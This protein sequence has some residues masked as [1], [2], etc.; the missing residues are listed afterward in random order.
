MK[1]FKLNIC[2]EESVRKMR[3]LIDSNSLGLF[4]VV[5]NAGIGDNRAFDDW[6]T[7]QMYQRFFDVNTLGHIRVTHVN[8]KSDRELKD[9]YF[10]RL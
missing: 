8:L 9:L 4:A 6:Q 3:E 7:P 1:A 10:Y 5:N 2:S